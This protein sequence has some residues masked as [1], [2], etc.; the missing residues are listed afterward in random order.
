[1]CAGV[2]LVALARPGAEDK[3]DAIKIVGTSFDSTDIEFKHGRFK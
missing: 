1:M 3:G 2:G